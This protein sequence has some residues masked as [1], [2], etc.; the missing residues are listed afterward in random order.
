MPV[1]RTHLRQTSI[2][3]KLLAYQT[4]WQS[5][6]HHQHFGWGNFRVLFVT[7]RAERAQNMAKAANNYPLTKASPIFLFTD[8]YG[9]Y[10][11]SDLFAHEWLN[12]F[13]KHQ[14]L[15]PS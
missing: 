14:K 4:I 13:G 11:Q 9:L 3:R 8:K 6:Q 5:K 1:E 7:T 2:L 15:L 12:C 10:G